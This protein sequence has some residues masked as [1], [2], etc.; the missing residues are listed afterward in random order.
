MT[1]YPPKCYASFRGPVQLFGSSPWCQGFNSWSQ[2]GIRSISERTAMSLTSV[3]HQ[4]TA[5]LRCQD[6]A[7]TC[8]NPKDCLE[9][10]MGWGLRWWMVTV[11]VCFFLDSPKKKNGYIY[12]YVHTTIY[13]TLYNIYHAILHRQFGSSNGKEMGRF[14]GDDFSWPH[15]GIHPQQIGVYHPQLREEC[16]RNEFFAPKWSE[17]K[18]RNLYDLPN[19]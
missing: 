18:F 9:I 4:R 12:I 17:I 11:Y 15:Q 16:P 8:E 5:V 1:T 2:V 6:L 10:E 14:W 19:S 7:K 3:F 13:I